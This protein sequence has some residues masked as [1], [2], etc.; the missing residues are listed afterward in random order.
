MFASLARGLDS[1]AEVNPGLVGSEPVIRHTDNHWPL[2][3]SIGGPNRP[4]KVETRGAKSLADQ[5][6]P[7]LS[8]VIGYGLVPGQG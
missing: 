2:S 7:R 6:E 3:C 4:R 1:P 8:E 5:V